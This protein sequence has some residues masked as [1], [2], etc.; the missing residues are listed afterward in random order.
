[1]ILQ[2]RYKI[3]KKLGQ[4]A[5]GQVFLVE[6]ML[7]RKQ[8][9]MKMINHT[10]MI[11]QQ[12]ALERELKMLQLLDNKYLPSITDAFYSGADSNIL[13]IIMDY[14]QGDS[15]R[16]Y[17]EK[18]GALE[19]REVMRIGRQL[20]EALQYLHSRRPGII[21]RD[22]K[23]DNIMMGVNG[24][25]KLIDF[26]TAFFTGESGGAYTF[27]TKGYAAPEQ[28]EGGSGEAETAACDIYALGAVLAFLSTGIDSSKPPFRIGDIRK[29]GKKFSKQTVCMIETCLRDNP[30]ER[31]QDGSAVLKVMR[32]D[33]QVKEDRKWVKS[34][35]KSVQSSEKFVKSSG[36]SVQSSEESVQ[37]SGSTGEKAFWL[38]FFTS[39][40]V[41]GYAAETVW[42][43]K[44][45]ACRELAAY[46]LF[47]ALSSFFIDKVFLREKKGIIRAWERGLILTQRRTA[48]LCLILFLLICLESRLAFSMGKP[49]F[50]RMYNEKGENFLVRDGTIFQTIEDIYVQLYNPLEEQMPAMEFQ[51]SIQG[52]PW[53]NL[54]GHTYRMSMGE[55]I[56]DGEEIQV[57]FR[58]RDKKSG[59]MRKKAFLITKSASK[60]NQD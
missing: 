49:L 20:A 19:E 30:E 24:N 46:S 54:T 32:G 2:K 1:M 26:G 50:I 45:E 44:F 7:C 47:F 37:S 6:D 52:S 27:G 36:K 60:E 53:K 4:G 22:I 15:L 18:K 5:M 12:Q 57:Q 11:I 3:L 9:A 28:M 31:F 38:L 13:C 10:G 58:G 41:L 8:R 56:L 51:V 17:V 40:A 21:H 29:S 23:P 35:G 34:N 43:E 39:I 48:G 33:E 42:V 25:I 16:E 55:G 59:Q 14:V